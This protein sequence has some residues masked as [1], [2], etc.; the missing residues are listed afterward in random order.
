MPLPKLVARVDNETDGSFLVRSVMETMCAE[1]KPVITGL[2]DAGNRKLCSFYRR[3]GFDLGPPF[4]FFGGTA[5][6]FVFRMPAPKDDRS[7]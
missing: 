4:G 7:C 5:S 1:G 6:T 2:L 3:I